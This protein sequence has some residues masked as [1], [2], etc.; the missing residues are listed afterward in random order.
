[1]EGEVTS[2]SGDVLTGNEEYAGYYLVEG[3]IGKV[4]G[5]TVTLLVMPLP[6]YLLLIY[7]YTREAKEKMFTKENWEK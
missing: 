6:A 5:L 2:V 3:S 1:M 7:S 4:D